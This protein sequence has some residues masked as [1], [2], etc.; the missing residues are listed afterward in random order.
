MSIDNTIKI[1]LDAAIV[2]THKLT[3]TVT[4]KL[5]DATYCRILPKVTQ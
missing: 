1:T 4:T 3:G 5:S 2:D